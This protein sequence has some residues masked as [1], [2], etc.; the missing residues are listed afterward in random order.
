MRPGEYVQYDI[1]TFSVSKNDKSPGNT[2]VKFLPFV[3]YMPYFHAIMLV[4]S[5]KH[6]KYEK[7]G[8]KIDHFYM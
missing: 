8:L 5:R 3:E 1:F 6:S 2:I 4:Y 7:N